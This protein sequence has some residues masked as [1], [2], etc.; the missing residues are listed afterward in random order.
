MANCWFN[1]CG[2]GAS[3]WWLP[4]PQHA[5]SSWAR[6]R[7]LVVNLHN[8]AN[9]LCPEFQQSQEF[10]SGISRT[11][12]RKDESEQEE[13]E[14]RRGERERDSTNKQMKPFSRQL[15]KSVWERENER[16]REMKITSLKLPAVCPHW[17]LW[18]SV[19]QCTLPKMADRVG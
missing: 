4:W 2:L 19:R 14:E 8:P 12:R 10:G 18:Q 3:D 6:T 15:P 16:V 13:G 5:W 9:A 1:S 17:P 11:R 7:Q